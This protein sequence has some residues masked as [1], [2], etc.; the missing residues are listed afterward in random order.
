[1]TPLSHQHE[2]TISGARAAFY[3]ILILALEG[4]VAA[5]WFAGWLS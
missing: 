4:G 3:V 5:A 2:P 1:M